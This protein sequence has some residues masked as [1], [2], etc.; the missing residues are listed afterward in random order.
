MGEPIMAANQLLMTSFSIGIALYP[1]DGDDFDSL[2]QKADT[3]MFAPRKPAV[4]D[5]DSLP[6]R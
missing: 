2:L 5:I 3:A 4:T 6:S 1:D